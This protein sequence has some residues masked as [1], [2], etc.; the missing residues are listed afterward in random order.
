MTPR[1]RIK[2]A[3]DFKKV[4]ALPWAN[5]LVNWPKFIGFDP[6]S[7]FGCINFSGCPIPVDVGPRIPEDILKT[8]KRMAT[9]KS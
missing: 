4:D 5:F 8:R 2:N 1:E 6:H 7:Y 3:M 9:S